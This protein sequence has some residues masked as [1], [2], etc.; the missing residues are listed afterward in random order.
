MI[1]NPLN[2]ALNFTTEIL[3][4]K[5]ENSALCFKIRLQAHIKILRLAFFK[6]LR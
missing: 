4:F 6:I 1:L 3:H 5:R 2:L